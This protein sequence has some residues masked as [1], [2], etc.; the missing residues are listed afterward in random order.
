MALAT[1]LHLVKAMVFPVIMYGCE[2]WRITKAEG[3][4]I[5]GFALWCRRRL[6]RVPCRARRSNQSILKEIN[7]EYL[8][9][10]LMLKL[11]LQ[12]LGYLIVKSWLLGKDPDAGK[13]WRQEEKG[14]TEDEMVGWYHHLNGHEF[15]QTPKDGKWHGSLVC[16]SPCG[17]RESDTTELLN[18]SNGQQK[19]G[20]S[21]S[22]KGVPGP[23]KG[24]T[25]ETPWSQRLELHV[26][27]YIL[28]FLCRQMTAS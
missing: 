24:K 4:R 17:H 16:C 27:V 13:D 1:K 6:L 3:R 7:P 2:S 11:K 22:E 28:A 26:S 21:L 12:Y 8:V 19:T 20:F 14:T 18:S 9:E 23:G 5:D 15:E 10:G 25:A